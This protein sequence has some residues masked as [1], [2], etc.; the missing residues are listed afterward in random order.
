MNWVEWKP[1]ASVKRT[2]PHVMTG[3][4][5]KKSRLS[6]TYC[7]HCGIISLR[8]DATRRALKRACVWEE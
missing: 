7:V 4:F 3:K 1:A 8:N 5:G 2:G 6:Y